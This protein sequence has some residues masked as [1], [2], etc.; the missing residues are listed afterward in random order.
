MIQG[1]NF[2][3]P[4]KTLI[5]ILPAIIVFLYVNKYIVKGVTNIG[6]K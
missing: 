3:N 4:G 5:G 1:V 2:V 6:I